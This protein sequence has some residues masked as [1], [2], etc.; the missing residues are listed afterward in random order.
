[1]DKGIYMNDELYE[2]GCSLTDVYEIIKNLD[3]NADYN[4]QLKKM[5]PKFLKN[6][7]QIQQIKK[8]HIG[9]LLSPFHY[10]SLD[11]KEI[12]FTYLFK[13]ER[14]IYN[15]IILIK[16]PKDYNQKYDKKNN[17]QFNICI[18]DAYEHF[19]IEYRIDNWLHKAGLTGF[20]L[21]ILMKCDCGRIDCKYDENEFYYNS[22][23]NGY[24]HKLGENI[25]II[26]VYISVD[27]RNNLNG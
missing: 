18:C 26:K 15:D 19:Y 5:N 3:E 22:S 9:W 16:D 10:V 1:M 2:E 7:Y 14:D 20:P 23:E 27:I 21:H 13:F 11:D 8:I 17:L 12:Y 24:L 25:P 6:V 4:E